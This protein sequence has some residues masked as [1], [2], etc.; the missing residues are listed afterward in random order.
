MDYHRQYTCDKQRVSFWNYRQI[1]IDGGCRL[2]GAGFNLAR[3]TYGCVELVGKRVVYAPLY[4]Y[5]ETTVEDGD[6]AGLDICI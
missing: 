5:A 6:D 2:F 1:V 3:F 4:M